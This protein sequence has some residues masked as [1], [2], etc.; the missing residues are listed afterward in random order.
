M[1]AITN[2]LVNEMGKV[3]QE[4]G[5]PIHDAT[6][7][8]NALVKALIKARTKKRTSKRRHTKQT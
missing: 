7:E 8:V 5:I 1:R 3:Y 6:P 4:F 2:D